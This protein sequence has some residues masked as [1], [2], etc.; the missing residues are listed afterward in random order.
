LQ[1]VEKLHWKEAQP[2]VSVSEVVERLPLSL[3]VV[4]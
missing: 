4:F 2:F 1:A 3:P